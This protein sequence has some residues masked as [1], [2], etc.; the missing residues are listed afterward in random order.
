[1]NYKHLTINK[2]ALSAHLPKAHE[3]EVQATYVPEYARRGDA[4]VAVQRALICAA[5]NFSFWPDKG[6][7]AWTFNEKPG[8]TGFYMAMAEAD[9]KFPGFYRA[10]FL[11]SLSRKALQSVLAG[12][13]EIPMLD[14]RA[15]ILHDV[16]TR[17]ANRFQGNAMNLL[18][19]CQFI[20]PKIIALMTNA[21]PTFRDEAL[22]NGQRA[23]FHK[24]AQLFCDESHRILLN[25]GHKGLLALDKLTALADYRVPQ[26]LRALGILTYGME[27]TAY[28][29]NEQPIEPGHIYE[30]EIRQATLDAV[31]LM[32]KELANQGIQTTALAVDKWLWLKSREPGLPLKPH[33][34]TRTTHY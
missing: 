33:H 25:R 20:A 30:V 29:D 1:M 23:T 12:P 22:C 14:E 5:I 17:M 6:Q 24:Q 16:G 7:A 11:K 13:V 28:V 26:V 31:A 9:E 32:V 8:S 4:D 27:L 2:D 15:E 3:L 34:R 10:T 21:M 19:E 18:Q